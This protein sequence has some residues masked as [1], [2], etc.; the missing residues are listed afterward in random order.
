MTVK[1]GRRGASFPRG[2]AGPTD[3]KEWG[4]SFLFL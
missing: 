4:I 3:G 1:L 2:C